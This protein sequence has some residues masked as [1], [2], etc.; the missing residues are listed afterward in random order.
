MIDFEKIA[1]AN[2][3]K[4]YHLRHCC[5]W[6]EIKVKDG[7]LLKKEIAIANAAHSTLG[8]HFWVTQYLAH[9]INGSDH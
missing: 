5:N 6:K 2:K 1:K 7:F 4:Y 8:F 9:S 3:V